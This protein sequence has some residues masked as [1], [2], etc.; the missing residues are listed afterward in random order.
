MFYPHPIIS[1]VALRLGSLLLLGVLACSRAD[2][3]ATAQTAAITQAA[4]DDF[5][6]PLP[7]DAAFA[8][9]VVSLNPTATEIIFALGAEDKLV[10]RSR[11]DEFPAEVSKIASLGDG[12]RPN[13]EAIVAARPTLVLLYA[14]AEN[15]SAAESLTR[16]GIRTVALKVDRIAD[17]FALTARLGVML[18]AEQQAKLVSDSVQR[19]LDAVRR[20]TAT[21]TPRSVVWPLWQ[22]PVMA[23]GGGSYLD[24]LIEIAGGRN[25]FHELP[26][27][28]PPV[29]IEEIVRRNPSVIVASVTTRDAL[30]TQPQWQAVS[31]VRTRQFIVHDPAKT[32]RPSVVLGMAAMSLARALHPDLAAQLPPM[33]K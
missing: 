7:A 28:S 17:F 3:R 11:W 8:A 2:T 27:P 1:R 5:G 4:V 33:A 25:I 9:R 31:A 6:A 20:I 18:G 24:E 29:S 19:T 16:A 21:S 10:G 15:R 14:S 12:I 13:V 32:G 22:Q 23:V 26:A 30:L